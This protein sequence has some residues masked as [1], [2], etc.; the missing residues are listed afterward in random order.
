ML[1]YK[2]ELSLRYWT[3]SSKSLM[4]IKFPSSKLIWGVNTYLLCTVKRGNARPQRCCHRPPPRPPV[5]R[6]ALLR[7]STFPD[8]VPC[9]RM[10]YKLGRMLCGLPL[11]VILC[12]RRRLT[13]RCRGLGLRISPN[14]GLSRC[15]TSHLFPYMVRAECSIGFRY[16]PATRWLFPVSCRRR[17]ALTLLLLG[18]KLDIIEWASGH[19]EYRS[20]DS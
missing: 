9:T 10:R 18:Y 16:R 13:T 20:V 14:G 17:L 15:S 7:H 8:G 11:Q 19:C 6:A 2:L 1:G 5:R 12:V 4:K 3:T